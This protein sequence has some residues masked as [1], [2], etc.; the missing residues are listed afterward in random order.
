MSAPVLLLLQAKAKTKC[1]TLH[2]SHIY[3]EKE[4][5]IKVDVVS[6]DGI[7]GLDR[8]GWFG[9]L[10]LTHT[11]AQRT[12]TAFAS[13]KVSASVLNDCCHIFLLV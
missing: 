6:A 10:V 3:V 2:L 11:L 1:G 8:S 7:L 13:F 4:E 5:K 12:T 9:E